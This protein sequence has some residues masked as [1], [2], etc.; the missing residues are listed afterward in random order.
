V[1]SNLEQLVVML[2]MFTVTVSYFVVLPRTFLGKDD[3]S[4]FF[5][6]VYSYLPNC[7]VTLLK[8]VTLTTILHCSSL[9]RG[10]PFIVSLRTE[11][12]IRVEGL[13]PPGPAV[14][15]S[16]TSKSAVCSIL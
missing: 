2:V 12:F 16:D 14:V 3:V 13:H 1:Y 8:T 5:R 15:L 6:D 11:F 9:L 10:V 7:T 4:I